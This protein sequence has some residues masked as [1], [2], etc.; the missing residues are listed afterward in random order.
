MTL[1]M[2]IITAVKILLVLFVVLTGVAYL[3]Y[4]ERRVLA[5]IQVRLGPNRVGPFG[6]LQPLADG[7]KFIF[8]EDVIPND[9]TRFLYILAPMI[10]LVPALM[11]FAVIPVG[12]TIRL[13]DQD[14]GLY[15]TSINVSV[16][17]VFAMT[18]LGIY[19]I[20][21]AGWSSNSK[22]S[23]FGGLRSSA[24]M[25]SYELALSLSI[26][27][28]L[29]NAGSLD[30][31][32]IVAAQSGWYHLGW[33]VFGLQFVGV[34]IFFISWLAE[35]NRVSFQLPEAETELVGG[36]H[37]EYS[38]MKFAMFFMAEYTS[39]ITASAMATVLFFGGWNGPGVGIVTLG[40]SIGVAFF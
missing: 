23:L 12:G 17:F 20:V 22:Y 40:P 21:L 36:F 29:M 16:L 34:V 39:M 10:A 35:T 38:A 32:K 11:T 9:V 30:L 18:S 19:G 37:T 25:V 2:F 24:Q 6:L 27:G 7:I 26:V 33:N 8:K 28:V 4:M 15:I 14:I 1:L 3:T 5:F 31:T 13:F